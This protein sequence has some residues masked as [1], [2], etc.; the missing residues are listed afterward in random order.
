MKQLKCICP[1]NYT[2]AV[3]YFAGG[4]KQISR[5]FPPMPSCLVQ[6]KGHV[7]KIDL[8]LKLGFSEGRIPA[9]HSKVSVYSM[10]LSDYFY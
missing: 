9:M 1:S 8:Y 5:Y 10:Y 3:L 7:F 4:K 6:L 2:D